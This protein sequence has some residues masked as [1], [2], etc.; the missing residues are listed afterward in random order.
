MTETIAPTA[1]HHRG[2]VGT[3]LAAVSAALRSVTRHWVGADPEP[4]QLSGLDVLAFYGEDA[5]RAW[6]RD[7]CP[8]VTAADLESV[9]SG[10]G[11]A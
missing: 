3:I 4:E 5:Y 1:R 7:G 6:R 9:V 2:P 11:D 8:P 10:S